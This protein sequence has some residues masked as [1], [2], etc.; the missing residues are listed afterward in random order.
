MLS[1]LIPTYNWDITQLVEQLVLQIEKEGIEY[2]ILANDDASNSNFN[3]INTK[4]NKLDKVT[5]TIS[6]TNTGLAIN[7]NSLAKKAK[8]EWLLFIDADSSISE[9]YI[10]NYIYSIDI[11]TQ[12]INGGTKYSNDNNV[13]NLRKT[14]GIK[15]EQ[16]C[17]TKRKRKP[18][19]S[20][21][22]NNFLIKKKIFD[23]IHFDESLK[24]YG[25][26]DTVFK[27]ELRDNNI[28]VIHI[29]APVIHRGLYNNEIFIKNT[30][31]A[32]INLNLLIK[33]KQ[34]KVND[35]SLVTISFKFRYLLNLLNFIGIENIAKKITIKTSSLFCFDLW[36]L[37]TYYRITN[38]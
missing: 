10:S 24:K 32:L 37:L 11:K 17:L 3:S 18:Y 33:K 13:S 36:R 5:F 12:V 14:Y 2:E 34:I 8:Y 4:L 15:R 27:Y 26:E 29:D 28:S 21:F 9:N 20:F 23:N 35:I 19:N 16:I 1:V 22:A 25:H 38:N 31:L 6:N 7:R 30:E